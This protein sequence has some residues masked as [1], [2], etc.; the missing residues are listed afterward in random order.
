MRSVIV[1]LLIGLLPMAQAG[2]ATGK[3]EKNALYE[4]PSPYLALHGR[5][6]VRW[7]EWN[8]K[9]VAQARA[10]NK[11]LFVSS[12]YFSCHW[13]HVMQRESF[14]NAQIAALLNEHF[15]PV[16]VDR[17]LDSALDAKLIDFVERT[18]G[19]SGWPLNVFVTP[20]GYPLVGMVYV[21]P[22]NFQSIVKK[23]H[24]QWQQDSESLKKLASA[25]SEELS[26]AKVSSSGKLPAGLAKEL[27]RRFAAQA[28]EYADDLQGGFGQENKFPSVPQLMTLLELPDPARRQF[29]NL[30]LQQMAS[31]GLRDQLQGGFYRYV[32]DPAWHIPHFEKMLYDNALLASLY[33]RAATALQLPAYRAVAD[34]TLDFM[35][36][37]LAVKDGA[38]IASLSAID[39]KGIEGGYYVWHE[40]DLQRILTPDEM[41]VVQLFWNVQGPPE[42]DDGHHLI[43]MR[44]PV[45]IGARLQLDVGKVEALIE[46]ARDK[47]RN[48]REKRQL[49]RDHKILSAWNGLALAALVDGAHAAG[50]SRYKQA[51]DRLF[52]YL[53]DRMWDGQ[54]LQRAVHEGRSLGAGNLEDY[55]YVA[56]GVLAYWQL[57]QDE[58]A[59]RWLQELLTQA[60]ER[61]YTKQGWL[62]AQDMLLQ[63]GQGTTLI[64]DG[65]MPSP[66]AVLI[67]TSYRFAR[68]GKHKQLADQALRA[69]NVGHAELEKDAFWHATQIRALLNVQK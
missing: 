65:P 6:P 26:S 57:T 62:L 51:A 61:F 59:G 34:D 13:C 12:G 8:E 45:D 64:S 32:V 56:H 15:V 3:A 30:T 68:A 39:D 33:Y 28:T 69:L 40:Q 2:Q 37:E 16:K 1:L 5:D 44:S 38:F 49:P 25:A 52:A 35:M 42:L 7:Q 29:L 48:V 24:V 21:P 4:H 47:L 10:Q 20:A 53:H 60:W 17:E 11:L 50:Q 18:Q 9:T 63:Y 14:Q 54:Q 67:D 66:A 58:K 55:A 46:S 22:D 31:L 43:Q 41:R 36:R 23:L 19:I 27:G